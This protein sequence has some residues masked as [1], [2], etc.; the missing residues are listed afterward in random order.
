MNLIEHQLHLRN[1]V[2]DPL[3]IIQ[4]GYFAELQY[5]FKVNEPG[6]LEL[7]L[8]AE[9]DFSL[10]KVDGQFEI[11]R[12]YGLTGMRLEGDTS[13]FIRRIGRPTF[14][15]GVK[16][17]K[18]TAY[19]ALDLMKR[20]IIPYVAG[21][22]YAEKVDIPWD[23]MLREI[24]YENYGPGASY[25]GASYGDDPARNLEPW[26]TVEPYFHWGASFPTTHSFPWRVV[27]NTLQDIVNEVRSNGVYCTFDVVR[28]GPA[29]FE[30]RVFLGPR[31]IDHSAGS[32]NPVIVSE[33][34]YNLSMPD[35]DEDWQEEKNFIYAAGQGQE[36]NR[37]VL[38]AQDD[39]RI[40]ISPFNRQE[41]LSDARNVYLPESVQSEADTA[42]EANRPRKV[43]TGMITQ[44]EGCIYGVHWGWG[45]IVTA[46]YEGQ[47]F[48]CYVEAVTVSIDANGTEIV[49]G[50][51]R[52][53]VD[54]G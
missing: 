11:Y 27:L 3:T 18:V 41:F 1:P 15:N 16:V 39:A 50:Q 4:D 17:R 42:L 32:A 35:I 6:V 26:L 10:L 23:D 46:E 24:V 40:G 22:S 8:P 28:V 43:F 19:S 51:L 30:F 38:T 45:D 52:S 49:Q 25:A 31:G 12:E 47:S 54:V 2:G 29:E 53:V 20:R 34:R 48:D 36:E 37:L 14:E 33:D 5:G 9:F 13:F 21:S 7:T 44:T